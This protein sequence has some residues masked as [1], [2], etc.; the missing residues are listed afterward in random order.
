MSGP[1]GGSFPEAVRKFPSPGRRQV[2]GAKKKRG[3]G[4]VMKE[5]KAH[6]RRGRAR[7]IWWWSACA[8]G[9]K[10]TCKPYFCHLLKNPI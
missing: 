1:E 6:H 4:R 9:E 5:K 3:K 7:L 8:G 2:E 10:K